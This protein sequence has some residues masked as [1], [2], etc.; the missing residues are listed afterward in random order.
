MKKILIALLIS[1]LLLAAGWKISNSSQFQFFGTLV[2]NV[3]KPDSVI[4]LTFDDGPTPGYTEEVLH[5]LD[6]MDVKATF[7]VIGRSVEKNMHEARLIVKDGNELGN[8]SWSHNRMVFKSMEFIRREIE[9]TDQVIRKAG[10]NG[11]ICFRPPYGK[12]LF[13]LP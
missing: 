5:V 7:F 9:K 13:I 6:S 3:S 12:K 8:H 2:D 4:A 10:Y 11:E 1:I